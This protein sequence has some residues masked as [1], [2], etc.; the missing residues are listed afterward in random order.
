VS[1]ARFVPFFGLRFL[2]SCFAR[3]S[4][5]IFASFNH[6]L[7]RVLVSPLAHGH[8]DDLQAKITDAPL[9]GLIIMLL[10]EG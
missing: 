10:L 5:A 9:A 4:P 8:R 1:V 7:E 2:P 6:S 3:F